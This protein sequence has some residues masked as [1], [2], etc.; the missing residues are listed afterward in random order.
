MPLEKLIPELER[1][2]TDVLSELEL[3][4]DN[5]EKAKTW[6]RQNPVPL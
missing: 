4:E 2:V 5:L 1:M 3:A 6:V